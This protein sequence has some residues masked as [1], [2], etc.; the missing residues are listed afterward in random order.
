MAA[1]DD[2]FAHLAKEQLIHTF[3]VGVVSVQPMARSYYAGL[4]P[5]EAKSFCRIVG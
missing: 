5:Y 3:A 4:Q 2:A 1:D